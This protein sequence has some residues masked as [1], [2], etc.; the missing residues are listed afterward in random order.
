MNMPTS[1]GPTLQSLQQSLLAMPPVAALQ[2]HILGW[3]DGRLQL[4][5]PLAANV[6]DKGCAFGGSLS[7]LMTLA[8][9]GVVTLTLAE[10]GHTADVFVADMQVRYL[11]PVF[12]DLQAQA[13]FEE[14]AAATALVEALRQRGRASARLQAQVALQDGTLAATF[15]GRFV[16]IAQGG[17]QSG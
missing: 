15:T 3:Q 6:N 17:A 2:V 7:A 1:W 13:G 4:G 14:P 16:A 8:A 12:E 9:W 11:A 10:A 5:A